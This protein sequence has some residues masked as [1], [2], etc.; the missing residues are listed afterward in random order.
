MGDKTAIS[1]VKNPDGSQGATWVPLT[2]CTPASEGCRRCFAARLASTRL[3]KVPAYAGLTKDGK[4]TGEVR[5]LPERLDQPW[6][7][8]KP[9]GIFLADMADLFHPNVPDHFVARCF[10]IMQMCQRH[11]FYVLTKRAERLASWTNEW[12]TEKCGEALFEHGPHLRVISDK[13][14]ERVWRDIVPPLQWPPPNVVVGVTVEN[15]KWAERRIPHLLKA[16]AALRFISCEPKLGDI[17]F[18]GKRMEWLTPLKD[19]DPGLNRTPRIDW[20]IIGGMN[21]VDADEFDIDGARS[22]IRQCQDAETSVFLKQL[23]SR[24]VEHEPSK[25]PKHV[26]LEGN[27]FGKYNV[28]GLHNRAGAD[29]LGRP[30][31]RSGGLT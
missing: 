19:Y 24:P 25:W 11:T 23:G 20:V 21:D 4:W 10:A 30:K 5:L 28:V 9:R 8:R 27:G 3:S 12:N 1:W 18:S 16:K 26:R 2:G 15:Q 7:W 6:R 14:H 22:L 29:G 31:T 13:T 17:G